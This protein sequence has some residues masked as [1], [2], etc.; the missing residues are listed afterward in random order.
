MQLSHRIPF[1]MSALDCRN[2]TGDRQPVLF[3]GTGWS[4]VSP[5]I[6]MQ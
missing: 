2:P 1:W 3:C 6:V 4:N 5:K